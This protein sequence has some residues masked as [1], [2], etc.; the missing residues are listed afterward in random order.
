MI[1]LP[2]YLLTLLLSA[3]VCGMYKSSRLPLIGKRGDVTWDSYDALLFTGA[4]IWLIII[5]GTVPALKPLWDAAVG[6]NKQTTTKQYGGNSTL[7]PNSKGTGYSSDS[8]GGIEKETT[9][10]MEISSGKSKAS[11]MV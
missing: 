4:E 6:R 2:K 10:D 9:I 7:Y 5:C 11:S 8:A 3:G 1:Y